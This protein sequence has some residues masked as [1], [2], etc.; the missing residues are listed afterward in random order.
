MRSEEDKTAADDAVDIR[1]RRPDAAAGRG[2]RLGGALGEGLGLGV[3]RRWTRKGNIL[4]GS[5]R[6]WMRRERGERGKGAAIEA[7][8]G[9]LHSLNI[10][11]GHSRYA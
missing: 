9:G 11:Y 1:P 5:D 6:D 8:E 7:A 4:D 3:G 10:G 2:N